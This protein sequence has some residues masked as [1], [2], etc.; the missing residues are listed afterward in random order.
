[1]VKVG[2]A[3]FWFKYREFRLLFAV[4]NFQC[5]YQTPKKWEAL[6]MKQ[7]KFL[8]IRLSQLEG[9]NYRI[10]N[11]LQNCTGQVSAVC[12]TATIQFL[13]IF[14]LF[15]VQYIFIFSTSGIQ[16]RKIWNAKE[17]PELQKLKR[18]I[19][20]TNLYHWPEFDRF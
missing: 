18:K 16:R 7:K 3:N 8:K 2:I 12:L 5:W 19:C 10:I 14:F 11:G 13:K 6:Y 15:Q 17:L 20:Y 1:M 4:K 9:R